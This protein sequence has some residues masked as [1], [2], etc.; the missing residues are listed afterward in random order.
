MAG[1]ISS[2]TSDMDRFYASW[3]DGIRGKA[4]KF[5]RLI[6]FVKFCLKRKWLTEDIAGDL[7]APEDS[8]L[9][10]PKA[11]FTDDELTRIYAA[12]DAIGKATKAGPGFRTWGGEDAKDFIYL[13]ICTGLRISDVAT[14]DTTKRLDGNNVFLRM[15]KTRRPPRRMS[16]RITSG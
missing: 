1:A 9:T 4:K 11:P 13:S 6:G 14:F 3:K 5:D 12:C 7:Q 8:S 2:S 15:H 10:I 16:P